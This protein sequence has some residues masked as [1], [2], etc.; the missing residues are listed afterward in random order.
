MLAGQGSVQSP[1]AVHRSLTQAGACSRVT[2]QPASVRV[3]W[4]TW[5]LAITRMRGLRLRRPRLISRPQEGG[6]SLGK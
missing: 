1:Q 3:A 2:D 6:Q 5:V 4:V